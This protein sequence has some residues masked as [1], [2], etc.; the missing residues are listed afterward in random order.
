[1]IMDK[2]NLEVGKIYLFYNSHGYPLG[3]GE[4]NGKCIMV[5]PRPQCWC[6][7]IEL[8]DVD[9]WIGVKIYDENFINRMLRFNK[10][11]D[12]TSTASG[13]T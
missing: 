3:C 12:G 10:E 11:Q 8:E 1:M 4:W 9:F 6:G 5:I 2:D 7:R 13:T